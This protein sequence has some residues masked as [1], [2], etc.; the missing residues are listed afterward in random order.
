MSFIARK[1]PKNLVTCQHTDTLYEVL[2]KLKENRISF[3]LIERAFQFQGMPH[4]R[5]E[6]VGVVYLT[7]LMYILRQLN[8][9]EIL[10]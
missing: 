8:F 6:T 3:I 7:D 4:P 10:T 9:S 1:E 2:Q 5:H